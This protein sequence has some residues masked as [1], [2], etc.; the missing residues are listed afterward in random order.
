MKKEE[1]PQDGKNMLD[2]Q[3]NW[4]NY[5]VDKDGK[6]V[7][8]NSIGWE[9]ENVAMEQAWE[10]VNERVEEARKQLLAEQLSPIGY[11]MEKQM[12]DIDMLARHVRKFSFQVRRHMKP[13]VFNNLSDG[14]LQRYATAFNISMDELLY[15]FKQAK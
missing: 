9:P 3:F 2:G 1:V 8:T 14:I 13:A 6:Y 12:M 4:L 15:P 7:K 5:A 10:V 11:Y